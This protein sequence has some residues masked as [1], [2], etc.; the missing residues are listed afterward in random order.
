MNWNLPYRYTCG[1]V[2]AIDKEPTQ[3]HHNTILTYHLLKGRG[4]DVRI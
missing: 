3:N 1:E 2:I 4:Y